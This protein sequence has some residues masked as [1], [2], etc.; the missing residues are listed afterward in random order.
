MKIYTM[1]LVGLFLSA[2]GG[3]AGSGVQ[4][5]GYVEITCAQVKN[6]ND[7]TCTAPPT[8]ILTAAITTQNAGDISRGDTV[9]AVIAATN[10]TAELWTGSADWVFETGC[11]GEPNWLS[12]IASRITVDPGETKEIGAG[13]GCPQMP[14]GPNMVTVTLYDPDMTVRDQVIVTFNIIE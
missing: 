5:V 2:C 14:L 8:A 7:Q 9:M 13:M 3:G 4:P 6:G 12:A 1:L 11:N 10:G